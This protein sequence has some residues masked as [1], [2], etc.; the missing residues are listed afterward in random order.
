MQMAVTNM[1]Q[2][3]QLSGAAFAGG[4]L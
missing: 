4:C 2:S 1:L 3:E